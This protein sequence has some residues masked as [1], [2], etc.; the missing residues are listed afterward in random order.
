MFTL[1]NP[2]TELTP[3]RKDPAKEA[4]TI[5]LMRI[6]LPSAM[7]FGLSGLVMG[8]LNS[9][10]VFFFPALAPSMYQFGMIFGVLVLY[11]GL[12]D[13]LTRRYGGA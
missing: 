13:R 1:E 9:H 8:I 7:I 12:T 3:D 6:M 5:N 2:I 4:L 11:N 10:Q